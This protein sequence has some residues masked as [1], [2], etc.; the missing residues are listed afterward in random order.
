MHGFGFVDIVIA[1]QDAVLGVVNLFD[2]DSETSCTM[3]AEKDRVA[4]TLFDLL[5]DGVLV[6][7]V[8]ETLAGQNA[9]QDPFASTAVLEENGTTLL[10]SER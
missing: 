5:L 9:F 3:L 8:R 2:G 6:E 4:L 1:A 10:C 7:L